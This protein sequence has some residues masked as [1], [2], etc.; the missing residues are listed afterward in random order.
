MWRRATIGAPSRAARGGAARRETQPLGRPG[1]QRT[2]GGLRAS[3]LVEQ[4]PV[5]L[6]IG[7]DAALRGQSRIALR[8]SGPGL[9]GPGGPLR[10]AL[11]VWRKR[12]IRRRYGPKLDVQVDAVEQRARQP[13]LVVFC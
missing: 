10:S 13:A 9:R 6:G 2:A 7:A 8:L 3:D 1:E 4:C 11:G 5:R 12:E